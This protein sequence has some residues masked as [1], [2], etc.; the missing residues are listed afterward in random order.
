MKVKLCSIKDSKILVVIVQHSSG[1]A[2]LKRSPYT[3]RYLF[4]ISSCSCMIQK[5]SMSPTNGGKAELAQKSIFRDFKRSNWM[6]IRPVKSIEKRAEK[7][8]ALFGASFWLLLSSFQLLPTLTIVAPH[9]KWSCDTRLGTLWANSFNMF[10]GFRAN[11]F[12][13]RT[14]G[15]EQN[16]SELHCVTRGIKVGNFCPFSES[17]QAQW[18]W[19]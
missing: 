15:G 5:L 12:P 2:F 8:I 1:F 10:H 11:D 3:T 19:K 4:Q 9:T 13:K 18:C 16:F 14:T 17:L 7:N 6:S